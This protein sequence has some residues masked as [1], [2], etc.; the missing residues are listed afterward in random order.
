MNTLIE[1]SLVD[2]SFFYM[3]IYVFLT[4]YST[5]PQQ[6]TKK[7]SIFAPSKK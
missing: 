2:V 1:T 4:I 6:N 3:D 5:T 7:M